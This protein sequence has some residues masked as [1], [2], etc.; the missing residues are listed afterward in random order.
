MVSVDS[1]LT[2]RMYLLLGNV[3][4]ARNVNCVRDDGLR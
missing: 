2:V 3:A 4:A 1:A